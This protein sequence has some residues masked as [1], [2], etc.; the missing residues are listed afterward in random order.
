M[1]EEGFL[2]KESRLI[3]RGRTQ[4]QVLKLFVVYISGRKPWIERDAYNVK[5]LVYTILLTSNQTIPFTL[6]TDSSMVK[7]KKMHEG[8]LNK[9]I[10]PVINKTVLT[11]AFI[12]N[13][14]ITKDDVSKI[15]LV[16]RLHNG[17]AFSL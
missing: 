11:R 7:S 14:W 13:Y 10:N 5:R 16:G 1:R 4:G 2:M 3:F 17:F 9:L 12:N 15:Q 8:M 6:N